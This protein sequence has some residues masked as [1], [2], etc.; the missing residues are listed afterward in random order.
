M[1]CPNFILG[2]LSVLPGGSVVERCMQEAL[3][4]NPT[5]VQEGHPAYKHMG[6]RCG[7]L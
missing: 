2:C 1:H 4:L 3:G 7:D 5:Q 6:N